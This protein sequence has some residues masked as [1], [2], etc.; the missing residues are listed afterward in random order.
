MPFYEMP[1]EW[2]APERGVAYMKEEFDKRVASNIVVLEAQGIVPG[3]LEHAVINDI[4]FM[5]LDKLFNSA[6]N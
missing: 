6:P 1:V 2:S 3:T 5:D 4:Q